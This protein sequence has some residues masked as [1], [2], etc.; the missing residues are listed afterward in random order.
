MLQCI[1]IHFQ[2]AFIH[3]KPVVRPPPADCLPSCGWKNDAVL[4]QFGASIFATTTLIAGTILHYP[5]YY[6]SLG[7][8]FGY[9]R[10]AAESI[11]A[12]L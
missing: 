3:V 12:V 8:G 9:L 2:F 11:E 4:R 5:V 1:A 6:L 10:E 7:V